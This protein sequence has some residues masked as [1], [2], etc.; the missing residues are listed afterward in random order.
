MRLSDMGIP[1]KNRMAA[2]Y[3][4]RGAVTV[5]GVSLPVGFQPRLAD[6]VFLAVGQE[7]EVHIAAN[8]I[9]HGPD[10]QWRECQERPEEPGGC[11]LVGAVRG[12]FF[13]GV[14]FVV[15][16]LEQAAADLLDPWAA[17]EDAGAAVEPDI[18]ADWPVEASSGAGEERRLLRNLVEEAR[19]QSLK[20][21]GREQETLALKTSLLRQSKPGVVLLGMP[22]VGKTAMVEKLA[23]EIA[24]DDNLP[25]GI[26]N[27]SIFDL[28]LSRLLESA[29]ILGD[30]QRVARELM[31]APDRPIFFLDE[32]HQLAHPGI[33]A[34]CDLFKPALAAGS[35]R[36][37]G[38]TT[39]AEW[40][41][42]ED[43]AFKRRFL[44]VHVP[45]PS[46]E[47]AFVMVR[48]RA[49]ELA[50]H[51]GLEIPDSL[52][53]EAVM[54]AVRFLPNRYLPDKA[55][56]LLDHTAAMQLAEGSETNSTDGVSHGDDDTRSSLPSDLITVGSW[57]RSTR[58]EPLQEG[59]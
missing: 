15:G 17:D 32:I 41:R 39:P 58:T 40:Q 5:P 13:S 25:A 27:V 1:E 14:N 16:M 44:E 12:D 56:D 4:T 24:H 11:R 47:E 33:S 31:E 26:R 2:E 3:R 50:E 20:V 29:Q 38:A 9:Y 35:L 46:P 10:P 8:A 22:G 34:L 54:L 6:F 49:R 28:P 36:V 21:V 55:I 51:H 45:E 52:V 53:R 43:E 59:D 30:V 7:C 18:G 37:I 42:L 48:A 23:H 57:P 19:T